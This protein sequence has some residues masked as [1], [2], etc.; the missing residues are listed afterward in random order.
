MDTFAMATKLYD[1]CLDMD[2]ADYEETKD[3]DIADLDYAL[4]WL[5]TASENPGNH[6]GF[7]AL[8]SALAVI[9]EEV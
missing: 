9:T 4:F 3:Q 7:R 8:F 5:K 6:D 2:F 1:M